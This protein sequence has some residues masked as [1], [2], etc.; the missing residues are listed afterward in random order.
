MSD[1][2]KYSNQATSNTHIKASNEYDF[3]EK[4]IAGMTLIIIPLAIELFFLLIIAV[5]T[6]EPNEEITLSDLENV[7][8]NFERQQKIAMWSNILTIGAQLVG[9]M[10]IWSDVKGL[11]RSLNENV[12][13]RNNN[14][15]VMTKVIN[16]K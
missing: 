14:L 13:I 4:T 3:G 12:S 1:N 7:A 2:D 8:E 9:L 15:V 10:L 5:D 11:S 6:S 16:K